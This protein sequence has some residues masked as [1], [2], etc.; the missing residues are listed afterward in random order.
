MLSKRQLDNYADVLLWGIKTAREKRYKK[1]DVVMVQ[2]DL[3]AIKLAEILQ[4]KLIDLGLNAVVR[5]SPTVAMERSLY[6]RANPRQL[7][8]QAPGTKELYSSL[9]GAMYLNAPESL[10]HL[11]DVEPRKISKAAIARKPFR[12][13]LF[14]REEMGEFGWTLCMLPT[15]AL[16]KHA[17]LGLDEY[18]DQVVRACY[19][20]GRHPTQAWESIY[21][22]AQGIKRWLNGMKVKHFHV[23]AETID[24]KVTPG[25]RRKWVGLSGHNI[26]SFELFLSPDWRGTEGKFFANQPSYRSGNY[27]KGVFLEFK[28]GTAVKA[29]A[30]KGEEFVRKQLAM[31]QGASRVG[32]FSLTDK[33]FSRIDKFM[34]NTLF[35]ENYGGAYGNCHIAVGSSYS[36]T[37]D[38]NPVD[39]TTERKEELGLNDSAL[40]WDLVNTQEKTVTAHLASGERAL[41]YDRGIFTY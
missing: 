8:F 9:N 24:L 14:R 2:F 26:P 31:D 5:L 36:D 11:K 29:S 13:V 6:V 17:G 10:T 41:I 19:L 27:V 20:D 34:A 40:H 33:R 16:A 21:E 30:A 22:S 4:G 37:Y 15:P 23:E 1:N 35:D 3:G 38:G 25:E 18:T 32:E 7:V 39:L 12:D 28:K